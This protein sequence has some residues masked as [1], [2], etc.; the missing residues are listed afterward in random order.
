MYIIDRYLLRMF[1]KTIAVLF[2]STTGLFVMVDTTSNFDEF[3]SYGKAQGGF[4]RVIFAYYAPRVLQFFDRSNGILA[5]VAAMFVVSWLYRTN[6]LTAIL[7]GGIPKS[8]IVKPLLLASG[9]ISLLG[10]ANR[11]LAIPQFREQLIYNAQNWKG[12]NPRPLTPTYDNLAELLIDG[13]AVLAAERRIDEPRFSLDN[14]GTAFGQR[15]SAARAY[16]QAATDDHPAGYLLV[17]VHEAR[18]AQLPSLRRDDRTVVYTPVDHAWLESN[19]LFVA[20]DVEFEQLAAGHSWQDLASTADLI[21]GLRGAT[22]DFSSATR[23]RVHARLVQ[24]FLDLTL[25]FIGLPLVLRRAQRNIFLSVGISLFVIASFFMVTLA[26]HGLGAMYLLSPALAAWLPL[27]LFVPLAAA[28]SRG[29][30]E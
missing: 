22:L 29:I 1:L 12:E 26:A 30:W 8:R 7:A 13:K 16:Q 25:V 24:P 10:V 28:L 18:Q 4:L 5:M 17:D 6:E 14:R 20:S 3:V 15:I 23:V 2:L 27:L 19:Q 11:E 21:R 9:L